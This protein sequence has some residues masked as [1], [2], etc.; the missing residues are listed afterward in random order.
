M[1]FEN[2]RKSGAKIASSLDNSDAKTCE[3]LELLFLYS[4]SLKD[5]LETGSLVDFHR[6]LAQNF[7]SALKAFLSVLVP[8]GPL[9]PP[10]TMFYEHFRA[11]LGEEVKKRESNARIDA[12][13]LLISKRSHHRP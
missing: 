2:L 7:A 1:F 13:G 3:Y 5:L 9:P 11:R 10:I 4:D 12:V 8:L 6:L